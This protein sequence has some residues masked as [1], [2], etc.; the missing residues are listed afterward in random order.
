MG[1]SPAAGT[2]KSTSFDKKLVDFLFK[3]KGLV[4]N[5]CVAMYVTTVGVCH[6][7]LNYIAF[8]RIIYTIIVVIF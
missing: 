3:P 2:K 6:F 7:R 1:S 5:H 4:C 8:V